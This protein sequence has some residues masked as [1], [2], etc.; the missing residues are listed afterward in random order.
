MFDSRDVDRQSYAAPRNSVSGVKSAKSN[1]KRFA[2]L[3][4]V[5]RDPVACGEARQRGGAVLTG[6]YRLHRFLLER[7]HLARGEGAASEGAHPPSQR[8]PK[9]AFGLP[10]AASVRGSAAVSMP[11]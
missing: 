7:D 6:S 10:T 1:S 11:V 3:R 5:V 4:R 8:I 2:T 9:Q